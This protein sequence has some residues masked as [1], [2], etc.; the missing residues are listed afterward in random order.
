MKKLT[1]LFITLFVVSLGAYAAEQKEIVQK[2]TQEEW[3]K[4]MKENEKNAWSANLKLEYPGEWL[5]GVLYILTDKDPM[6]NF[7]EDVKKMKEYYVETSNLS[8]MKTLYI[9]YSW[10]KIFDTVQGDS[11]SFLE[12]HPNKHSSHSVS[13]GNFKKQWLVTKAIANNGK[14]I[15]WS[16]PLNTKKG[17]TI[18]V[19]LTEKNAVSNDKLE[20]IYDSIVK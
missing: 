17:K 10:D 15:C 1:V 3:D 20:K 13:S 16:I 9:Q 5:K 6:E 2:Y 19:E 8:H 12:N 4:K 18:E 7:K 11:V 14:N